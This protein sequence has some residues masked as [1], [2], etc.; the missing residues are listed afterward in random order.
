MNRT[1]IA[2]CRI[3]FVGFTFSVSA[4]EA[5]VA[6]LAYDAQTQSVMAFNRNGI[7]IGQVLLPGRDSGYN[8]AST[9]LPISLKSCDFEAPIRSARR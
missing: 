6:G 9:S 5:A 3:A 2:A 4:Q 8:L 7:P 1:F